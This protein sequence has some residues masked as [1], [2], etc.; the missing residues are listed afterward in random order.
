M[1]DFQQGVEEG[2]VMLNRF[3]NDTKFG[4]GKKKNKT[5]TLG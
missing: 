3:L 4:F 1:G 2:L 5:N